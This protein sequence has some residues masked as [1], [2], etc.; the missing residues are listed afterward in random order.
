MPNDTETNVSL[1]NFGICHAIIKPEMSNNSR[2]VANTAAYTLNGV[3]PFALCNCTNCRCQPVF[4]IFSLA[5]NG[6]D[7][8]SIIIS[9]FE[10]V[11]SSLKEAPI[12][13]I[14]AWPDGSS[15]SFFFC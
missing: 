12:L 3:P 13:L 1:R 10:P 14:L 11:H 9:L 2:A 15:K 6:C 4:F 7:V 5:I 8:G